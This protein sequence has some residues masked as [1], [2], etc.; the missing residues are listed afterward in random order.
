[1]ASIQSPNWVSAGIYLNHSAVESRA[2]SKR[3]SQI[4]TELLELFNPPSIAFYS[5]HFVLLFTSSVFARR[6][7]EGANL[8]SSSRG[9]GVRDQ[10]RDLANCN[11]LTL[12]IQSVSHLRQSAAS[13]QD[14]P[15]LS[16]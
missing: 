3:S 5:G 13:V 14:L 10:L 11:G 16:R 2:R 15:G 12:F 7:I 8:H 4:T 1:M 9:I 6:F